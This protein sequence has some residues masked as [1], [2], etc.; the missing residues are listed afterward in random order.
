MAIPNPTR[1]AGVRSDETSGGVLADGDVE[2]GKRIA[3]CLRREAKQLSGVSLP[4]I[5]LREAEAWEVFAGAGSEL[6]A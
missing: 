2:V 1:L 3:Q 5:A 6:A 4:S